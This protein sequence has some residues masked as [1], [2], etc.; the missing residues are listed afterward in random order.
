MF[1]QSVIIFLVTIQ[2]TIIHTDVHHNTGIK[3]IAIVSISYR[4]HHYC[5]GTK[6]T[7]NFKKIK[8]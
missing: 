7:K 2:L 1:D 6:N 3:L 5:T 4:Y 8:N